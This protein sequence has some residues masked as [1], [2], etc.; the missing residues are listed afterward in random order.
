[1]TPPASNAAGHTSRKDPRHILGTTVVTCN[2]GWRLGCSCGWESEGSASVVD[3]ADAWA[4]HASADGA[5]PETVT[6]AS[7]RTDGGPRD[8][9]GDGGAAPVV[10]PDHS[11]AHWTPWAA[12]GPAR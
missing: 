2:G 11:T 9:H 8:A 4:G 10:A 1:M 6:A 7:D 12:G 3:I 5:Q